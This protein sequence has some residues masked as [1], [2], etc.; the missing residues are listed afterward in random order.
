[1][2]FKIAVRVSPRAKQEYVTRLADGN[3]R[4]AVHAPAQDGK[5][6]R[7]LIEI[8]ALH[9]SVPKSAIRILRG[10]RGRQKLIEI[11]AAPPALL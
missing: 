2:S 6:N 5:A 4:V 3:Y 7:A 8:L 1:M 11:D 9:F 10:Q